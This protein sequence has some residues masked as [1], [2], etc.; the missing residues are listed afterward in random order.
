MAGRRYSIPRPREHDT[1]EDTY[2][3]EI[4]QASADYQSELARLTV[5]AAGTWRD[6]LRKAARKYGE[7]TTE[8]AA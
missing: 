7:A 5:Q 2:F 1:P 8:G 4:Q 6:R 3:R